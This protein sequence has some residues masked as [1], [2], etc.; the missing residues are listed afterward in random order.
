MKGKQFIIEIPIYRQE[1]QI[2]YQCSYD[3]IRKNISEELYRDLYDAAS[4]C[5]AT[6]V[7]DPETGT[8]V[9]CFHQGHA[10]PSH[11]IIAHEVFHVAADICDDIGIPLLV[12]NQEPVAYMITHILD[13]FYAALTDK[14]EGTDFKVEV[15]DE[16]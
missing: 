12:T 3:F 6:T 16:E 11:G 9:V 7:S 10:E 5:D 4:E 14:L 1:V 8:Y 15:V 13:A 2:F